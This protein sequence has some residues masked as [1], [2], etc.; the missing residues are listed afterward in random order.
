MRL[1]PI[2]NINKEWIRL[3]LTGDKKFL[4]L[5]D[6]KPVTVPNHPEMAM[7]K[8]YKEFAERPAIKPY[9]PDKISKGRTLDRKYF[10]DVVNSFYPEEMSSILEHA[11]K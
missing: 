2:T 4:S 1:P 9:M 7:N 6:V 11:N 5:K 8:L 10:F 3:T